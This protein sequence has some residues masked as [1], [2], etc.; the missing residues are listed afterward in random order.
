MDEVGSEVES[1][2]GYIKT[3]T[4]FSLPCQH[5]MVKILLYLHT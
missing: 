3:N 4:Y 1:S 2:G 5:Y